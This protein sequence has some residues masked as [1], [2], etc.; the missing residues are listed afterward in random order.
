MGTCCASQHHARACTSG[1]LQLIEFRKRHAGSS[2]ESAAGPL[3]E[4]G[5]ALPE[6][7]AC[8]TLPA[9][10]ASCIFPSL[11]STGK[12]QPGASPL[13]QDVGE[14][15][16]IPGQGAGLTEWLCNLERGVSSVSGS[17]TSACSPSPAGEQFGVLPGQGSPSQFLAQHTGAAVQHV[18]D[19]RVHALQFAPSNG[20]GL[21]RYRST[22]A[23]SNAWKTVP[24]APFAGQWL[25]EEA[26]LEATRSSQH[27]PAVQPLMTADV[28]KQAGCERGA[29]ARSWCEVMS[30]VQLRVVASG[31]TFQA[32]ALMVDLV[33]SFSRSKSVCDQGILL[34][35]LPESEKNQHK[36]RKARLPV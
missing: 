26:S 33:L 19:H 23:V 14:V 3:P 11:T 12:E 20:V 16:L 18:T 34:S 36:A 35:T 10:A 15:R 4:G 2:P 25:A 32:E 27:G 28:L 30:F 17:T 7:P 1:L 29:L 22:E 21:Y 24:S 6:S 5:I 9:A 8:P 31:I 13:T